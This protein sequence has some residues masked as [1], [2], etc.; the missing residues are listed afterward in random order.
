MI[1][2]YYKFKE[3]LRRKG[4]LYAFLRGLK[5]FI[6]LLRSSCRKNKVNFNF[7][8]KGKTS[9][10]CTASG[11]KIFWGNKELTSGIGLHSLVNTLGLWTDSVTA[12]WQIIERGPDYFILKVVF[13][14]LPLNQIWKIKIEKQERISL[15]IA[16]EVEEELNI[17]E[18]RVMGLVSNK[19]KSWFC[20]Y[21]QGDF[22]RL[23][24]KFSDVYFGNS[25]ARLIG[26]RFPLGEPGFLNA[27]SFDC[28]DKDWFAVIQN[29][30]SFTDARLV[31]VRRV[32]P[33]ENILRPGIC[34]QIISSGLDLSKD[35]QD[36]DIKVESIRRTSLA[37]ILGTELDNQKRKTRILL[38]NLPWQKNGV[39]GVRAGSRWPHI[40]GRPEDSYLP[41]PFFLAYATALLRSRDI[42]AVMIDAIAEGLSEEKFLEIV[43]STK[44]DYLVTETS[45]PSFNDDL[46]L[47][48]KI[49]KAGANI[50]LCG[51]NYEIY[52]PEFLKNHTFIQFV[53]YGEYE[54]TLLELV[55]SLRDKKTLSSVAGL[56]YRDNGSVQVNS[57]RE[58]F[59][60]DLLPW[61]YR[62]GLPMD[63]YLDAP[64][65]MPL[66]S[67]QMIASRGCPFRCKFCLWPQVVYQG[68]DY[69][70]RSVQ[71]VVSEM[72]Y[73]VEEKGFRSV[74]FDDDTFNIGKQRMLDFCRQ[75]KERKLNKV[76]WAIM[77]RPDLMDEEI[78]QN[79]KDAG[80]WAVKYGVESAVQ[81]LLDNIDKDMDL[82]KAKRMIEFSK[83]IGLK[84]H[85]TFTFGLPQETME[86]IQETIDYVKKADPYSAQ[87]SITTP[88]P[89]TEYYKSLDGR[90]M[91]LSKDFS[92]YDG[93]F[94]SVIKLENLSAAELEKG[95]DK[96]TQAWQDHLRRKD[97]WRNNLI[98]L[99]S[100]AKE[101][102][103]S[104]AL[105]KGLRYFRNFL[106]PYPAT[107]KDCLHP[108]SY[109]DLIK[110]VNFGFTDILLIQC[111][112]WDIS[113]PPLG[114]AYLSSYLKEHGY[115][116]S[117]FD[118]N[119]ALY[120]LAGDNAKRLWEQK[121]YDKWM[122]TDSLENANNRLKDEAGIL[123]T[124]LLAKADIEYIGLS[125]NLA[126]ISMAAGLIKI[127]K[128]QKPSSK[129]ILGGWG[130]INEH[131]RGLFPAGLVDVF[132][133]GEG[134]AT[135]LEVIEV[136]RGLKKESDV[137]G[138][139]FNHRILADYSPRE[140]I[141]DL[142]V[143]PW[144]TF[145]EF[146]LHCY[147]SRS[148]PIFTSRGCIG[149]CSFCNDWPNSTPYR[150][151]SARS[152]MDEIIYH[153]KNNHTKTFSFKDLLCN[154]DIGNLNKL[155]DLII[156]SGIKINWDSQ[157]IPRKEMTYELLL[158]LK[159]S[160]CSTLIYGIES[161]SDNVLKLMRKIFTSSVAED[162]LKDTWRAGIK[163]CINIIVGFPGETD[164]DF[165]STLKAIKENRQYIGQIGAISVCLVNHNSDLENNHQRYNLILP[166]DTRIRAKEWRSS[167]NLSTYQL[168]RQRAERILSMANEIGLKYETL[169]I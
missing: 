6:F 3:H 52:K 131:M 86:T 166:G 31:G 153:I 4:L 116:A 53:L 139:I 78:L 105:G 107:D 117:V 162:V 43:L 46:C 64:G 44:F 165:Q 80:L 81:S 79:M 38:V 120:N 147:G 34:Y 140:P 42:E 85:L 146:N 113:M 94:K 17:D 57:K 167:D 119:I 143:I 60:L 22:S 118:L 109:D 62:E 72:Q 89:G 51:P 48:E 135:L 99:Y 10:I 74:Y 149:R 97:L 82:E 157:A 148:L 98:K 134:E 23:D 93:Q 15:D 18:L 2:N 59:P 150:S 49:A 8:A 9:I 83:K 12:S 55:E 40:K 45:V 129:I 84:V 69:R 102:G 75:I 163:S 67:V 63:K 156:A 56:I 90:G 141:M 7:I 158:K 16:L 110:K 70:V 151:R 47:L 13:K 136:F 29:P 50:I 25:P 133:V 61:P 145:K 27:F 160:G 33:G 138:A 54:F 87:F 104:Y 142:N 41:F 91:I 76:K 14:A 73:L 100:L 144:P 35:G 137:R 1:N 125:V 115:N 111:P 68:H 20:D 26:V 32:Y 154:G 101:K 164:E 132:V 168:R 24:D 121:N 19:Y 28:D 66:P 71:D 159:Q 169:T 65:R 126:G 128:L 96:A 123:L 11:L 114:V 152:I 88:F 130:C 21:K 95:K 106:F 37:P 161:F 124:K 92:D 122:N 5:Y 155:A 30:P 103:L 77:A 112:P 39:S 36:L 127:I 58:P 108:M